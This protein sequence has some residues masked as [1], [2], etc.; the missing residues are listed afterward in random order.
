MVPR[1]FEVFEDMKS[2]PASGGEKAS[3]TQVESSRETLDE[4]FTVAYEELKRIA[5]SLKRGDRN[6]TLN[7]T[8]LVNETWLKLARSRG[9]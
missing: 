8:A 1:D 5:A 2:Q 4:L 3:A 6:V 9:L 7:P